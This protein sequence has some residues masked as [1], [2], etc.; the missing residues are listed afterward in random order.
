MTRELE[1]EAE[2]THSISAD[3]YALTLDGPSISPDSTLSILLNSRRIW[4]IRSREAVNARNG[5]WVIE[6]PAALSARLTGWAELSVLRDGKALSPTTA[7]AFDASPQRFELVEPG[8]GMPQIINKWGRIARN[9]EGQRAHLID[10]ALDEAC[11][12][13]EWAKGMGL[14]LF[15]TGGTLLGPVRDG[16]IM[17]GDDDVD[18][19]YLSRHENPS[20][21][22]LEGFALERALHAQGYETVRHSAGHLQLLFPGEDGTDRFYLDIFT[23]FNTG[24][25]F[26]G[27]FH[28][29]ELTSKVPILPLRALTIQGRQLP[30]PAQ[31][32]ALLAA[33]Y[34]RGWKTPD[35]GFRFVTPP[36]ARRRYDNWLGN[37]DGDRENWEDHHRALLSHH[38]G[39]VPA[40]WAT[41]IARDLPPGSRILE[42]GCGLGADARH[43]A[44]H[45]HHVVAV[46]YS[47]P[48]IESL[49]RFRTDSRGSLQA[50][51]VNLNNL[52]EAA[53]LAR[54]VNDGGAPLFVYARLLLDSLPGQGQDNALVPIGHLLRGRRASASAFLEFQADPAPPPFPGS[55]FHHAVAPEARVARLPA[56]G[57]T[58]TSVLSPPP[59][60]CPDRDAATTRRLEVRALP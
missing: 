34:G 50:Q 13:V 60:R 26:H 58:A 47:R 17:P 33:I 12:L 30:A 45:G 36:D 48:A 10:E 16:R 39:G 32:E 18:L 7:V 3:R 44:A 4:S 57:L 27:T 51:R 56:L 21:I 14:E 20:D 19:A 25:W 38:D 43:F 35:P 22:A 40:P 31:P 2:A 28:A 42:L 59:L 24:G 46:D 9:F 37:L 11:A 41:E 49:Q 1:V 55:R 8:S 52:R 23:Y 54:L 29:R 53:P 5:A 15:V 6:W